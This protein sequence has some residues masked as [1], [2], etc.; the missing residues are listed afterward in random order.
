MAGPAYNFFG[1][2]ADAHWDGDRVMHR[3]LE[4]TGGVGAM[5]LQPF[6]AYGSAADSF[7]DYAR[8]IGNSPRYGAARRVGSSPEAYARA[9]Q[10]AGYA[11]DPDYAKQTAGGF[12]R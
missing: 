8:L 6:R 4:V 1:I 3:T 2:K 5:T 11:T 10:D 9:L 7:A 12:F